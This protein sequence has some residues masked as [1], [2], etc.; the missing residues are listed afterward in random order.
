MSS[1]FMGRVIRLPLDPHRETLD[2]APWYATDRLEPAEKARVEAHLKTC[3]GCQAEVAFQRQL[4]AAIPPLAL[5]VEHGWQA[6]RARLEAEALDPPPARAPARTG[7]A[8]S[9]SGL[10]WAAA[11]A[12][13]V[14]ATGMVALRPMPSAPSQTY[15][16]LGSAPPAPTGNLV[17]VF[18]P[19]A[20]EKAMR[21]ALNASHARLVDGPTTADAYVLRVAPA[22]R[23]TALASLR[24]RAEVVLAE[25]IDAAALR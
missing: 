19:D 24:G 2:L 9:T 4:G 6:M 18:R 12:I 10:G 13:A 25:P 5:D 16:A 14:I 17:V 11:A 20:T 3:P 7:P 1:D 21:E 22:E 15:H 23:P 8:W